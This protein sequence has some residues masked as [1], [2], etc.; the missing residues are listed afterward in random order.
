MEEKC[1][2]MSHMVCPLEWVCAG[3][4]KYLSEVCSICN[5]PIKV[6][7]RVISMTEVE[8]KTQEGKTNEA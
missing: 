1:K 4:T 6:V 8:S 7:V 2:H 5:K 3:D